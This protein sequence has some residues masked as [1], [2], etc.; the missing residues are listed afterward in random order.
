LL[1]ASIAINTSGAAD[2]TPRFGIA[3]T[4]YR[5]PSGAELGLAAAAVSRGYLRPPF[6]EVVPLCKSDRCYQVYSDRSSGTVGVRP[7]P[8]FRWND[9]LKQRCFAA[10]NLPNRIDVEAGGFVV[11]GPRET[12][13]DRGVECDGG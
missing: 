2:R 4:E 1:V 13:R 12:T 3:A 10:Q 6:P 9:G 11:P 5:S 8:Q 7:E